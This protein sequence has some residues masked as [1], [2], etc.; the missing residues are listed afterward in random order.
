MHGAAGVFRAHLTSFALE[1]AAEAGAVCPVAG[2]GE[3]ALRRHEARLYDSTFSI[4]V[5]RLYG[6]ANGLVMWY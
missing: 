5:W 6:G 2:C 1:V 4:T 3:I